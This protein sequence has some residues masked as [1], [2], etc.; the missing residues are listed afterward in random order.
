MAST[1]RFEGIIISHLGNIAGRQPKQENRLKYLKAALAAGW[2]VCADVVFYQGSFLLPFEGGFNPAPP[3]FFSGQRVW[4]RCYNAETLDA[5]CNIN[6]HAFLD[7]EHMPTLTSSQF[8]WT[9][10]NRE[11]SLRSIAYLPETAEPN[12]VYAYEPAGL[13]SNE[14]SSYV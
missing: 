2:H 12:W 9:P 3:S 11:L 8:I 6:A 4:S 10:A 7:T 14:P 5:L 1:Q 13:C